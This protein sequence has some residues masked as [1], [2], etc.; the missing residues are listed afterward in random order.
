MT[1]KSDNLRYSIIPARAITDPAITAQALRVLALL[2]R[3]TNDNGWCRRSQVQMAKELACSRGTI[4]NALDL[5]I[6]P[7]NGDGYVERREENRPGVRPEEGRHPHCAYSYR[8]RLDLDDDRGSIIRGANR[9]ARD[10]PTEQQAVPA[11][12]KHGVPASLAP[13]TEHTPLEHSPLKQDARERAGGVGDASPVRKQ[14]YSDA[15]ERFWVEVRKWP[16]FSTI[17][18]KPSAWDVWVVLDGVGDLLKPGDMVAAAREYGRERVRLNAD[19]KTDRKTPQHTKHPANWL[20]DKVFL[21]LHEALNDTGSAGASAPP[22]PISISP[23]DVVR[24]R[25]AGLSDEDIAAWF[26]E[27]EFEA[28]PPPVF[29]AASRFKA[30]WISQRYSAHLQRA[31]G[32]IVIVTFKAAERAA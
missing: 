8:V 5:L 21:G 28:G 14:K 30:D 32:A 9:L 22:R 10:V 17:W 15:F 3:H 26:G 25:G 16:E 13:L 11:Q 1:S 18:S 7:V 6:G 20:R 24:L 27:G 2:G 29:R 19:A 4:Q 23:D 31:F 12:E